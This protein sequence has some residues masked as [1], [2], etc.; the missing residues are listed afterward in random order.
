MADRETDKALERLEIERSAWFA[1]LEVAG[2]IDANQPG[3]WGERSLRDLLVHL[4]FWQAYK[5]IRLKAAA[6]ETVARPWPADLNAIS[7]ED[8][9]VDAINAWA[10]E[11]SA[12]HST[13]AVIAESHRL[14]NE[15]FAII[16]AMPSEARSDPNRFPMF[17]GHSLDECLI[18]GWYFEHYHDEHAPELAKLAS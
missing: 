13:A 1:K 6:G 2:A 7:N 3:F 4:N 14:W 10:H 18:E 15:Q 5:N 12:Q 17:E 16:E 11:Q 9:L 8:D